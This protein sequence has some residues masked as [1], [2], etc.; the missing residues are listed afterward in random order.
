MANGVFIHKHDS[1]YDD[2]PSKQY[3]FPKQY[4]SRAKEFI[5]DWIVYLEPSRV[6]NTKGYFA[7]AK[8]QDIIPD[9]NLPD[10]YLAIIEAGSY[11]DFGRHVQFKENAT[12]LEA[13]LLNDAGKLSGRAQSAVR[14]ISPEDF[15]RIIS[16]GLEAEILPRKNIAPI[17][18][19]PEGMP[20]IENYLLSERLRRMTDRTIRDKNF[21]KIVLNAYSETCAMTGLRL[22][23]GGGRAEA[24]AAHIM[25]VEHN[26]PDIVSNG[27]ALSGT[28]H[29]MF[30]RGLIG[31]S[32]DLE[33][34]ISRQANDYETIKSMIN[35]S[36]VLLKPER[37]S[38]H[39]RQEF[40]TWHRERCFKS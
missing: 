9:P 33:I 40:I 24:E 30:D 1:I 37:L 10:M 13:G 15:E 36:G 28:A 12:H 39:P 34:L 31:L 8:V 35:S 7:V 23:N 20:P 26:G 18:E 22:I 3:Q 17:D 25:P 14:P 29:W 4:F 16:R 11:L 19:P 2:I 38:D 32:K 5:N 27:I 6:P 21:R